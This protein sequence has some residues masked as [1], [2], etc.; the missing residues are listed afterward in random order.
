MLIVES[1]RPAAF[2]RQGYAR[3]ARLAASAADVTGLD[4]W[5]A[6]RG[7]AVAFQMRSLWALDD[8]E[9]M[10]HLDVPGWTYKAAHEVEHFLACLD[11]RGRV[12]EFGSGASTT[13]LA[14]RAGEVH[15]VEHDLAVSEQLRPL[16]A[17]YERHVRLYDAPPARRRGD[18]GAASGR[19]GWEGR[20]FMQYVET[21]HEVGSL[22]DAI[23]IE[24]RA[25]PACLEAAVAHLA[26]TGMIVFDNACRPR[27][28]DA[29]ERCGLA[30]DLQRGWAPSLPYR[31]ATALLRHRR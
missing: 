23:V 15:A 13:W 2:I 10:A 31:E 21:I 17:I 22:F 14:Q 8:V 27:Y 4:R 9:R 11:G 5:L 20:D 29:I 25:R 19:P 7:S 6:A 1:A 16:L 12:F 3:G 26:P 30:V 24:G 28:R 18:L